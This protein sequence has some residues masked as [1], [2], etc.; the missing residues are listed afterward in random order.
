MRVKFNA[1]YDHKW[2]SRAMTHFPAGYEGTVK[3]EVGERAIA[4]G[5]A[6]EVK[7][8]GK[9]VAD[10]AAPA[11]ADL[12]TG[13]GMAKPDDAHH[14]GRIVRDQIMDGADK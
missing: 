8:R 13:R 6:T 14:V 5:R 9:A 10:A 2:P 1:D 3:R 4:K 7:R 11:N 12:G